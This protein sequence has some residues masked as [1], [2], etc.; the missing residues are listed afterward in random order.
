MTE[1][2]NQKGRKAPRVLPEETRQHLKAAGDE[3]RH[4]MEGLFPPEFV[5]HNRRARKEFLLA[6]RSLIDHALERMEEASEA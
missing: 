3:F 6:A 2:E 1:A 5:D 4:G